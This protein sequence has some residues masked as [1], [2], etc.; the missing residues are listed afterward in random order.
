MPKYK[1]TATDSKGREKQGVIEAANKGAALA[2]LRDMNLYPSAVAEVGAKTPG[3]PGA[4]GAP[5]KKSMGQMQ[6]K[7]SIPFLTGR[8]KRKQLMTFTRQLATLIDAGVPL[9][10]SLQILHK[11]EPSQALKDLTMKLCESVEGGSTFA[12]ALEQHPKIFDKLFTNMVRAGEIGGVLETT[13][14]RL[15]EFMEKADRIRT[16]VKGAMIYP[17]VVLVAAVGIVAFLMIVII[18]KFAEIF[19]GMLGGK[20]MPALTLFVIKASDFVAHNALIVGGA[21]A[22]FFILWTLF[23]KTRFGRYVIDYMKI[24]LPMMGTL[25]LRVSIARFTRTLGTLMTSGVQILQALNIVKLTSGNEIIARSIQAVHDSVKEGETV[26][27]PM[28]AS[29][30]YPTMVV[31]MISVGEE[32]GRLPEMLTKIA[33]TYDSEVDAAVDGL[34]SI[35]EPVLIIFLAVVVGTVVIAMF[36][37]LVS[38]ISNLQ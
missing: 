24:K 5:K 7:L 37:P 11:Q 30:V 18:P 33:D 23:G 35:I 6:I 19:E 38:I 8:I 28:E 31:S 32:T 20:Q 16:K 9:L 13:L 3:A 2:S 17:I 22:A 29:G 21:L 14:N 34:T 36:M 4:K 1:Y 26:A 10:R 12:E 25:I 15:A 27:A